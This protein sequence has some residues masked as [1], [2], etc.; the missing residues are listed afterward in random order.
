MAPL[1]VTP[2]GSGVKGALVAAGAADV[3]LQ[4]GRAGKRWDVCAPEAILVAAGGAMTDAE[5]KP[6][7]YASRE[8]ENT[9]GIVGTNGA[10][11]DAVLRALASG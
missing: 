11:H 8:L 9:G 5:G 1:T 4:V 3:Y 7:D 2:F 6:L 10:L